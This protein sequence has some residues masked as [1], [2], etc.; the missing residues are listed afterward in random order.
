METR[1][2]G[3]HRGRRAPAVRTPRRSDAIDGFRWSGTA[4]T[5]KDIPLFRADDTMAE[6]LVAP[7]AH[8]ED[9]STSPSFVPPCTVRF[10]SQGYRLDF[11]QD[12]EPTCVS[13]SADKF[14]LI[15]LSVSLLSGARKLSTIAAKSFQ[16]ATLANGGMR[17]LYTSTLAIPCS[18]PGGRSSR[19]AQLRFNRSG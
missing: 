16:S 10:P 8:H 6:S 19:I 4:E 14:W 13:I 2:A 1:T 15:G 5:G 12:L 7:P 18:Q 17:S 3:E 9:S 11:I